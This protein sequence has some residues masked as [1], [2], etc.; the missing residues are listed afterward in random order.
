MYVC[1]SPSSANAS[2]SS[3]RTSRV[4]WSWTLRASS[5][6]DTLA[7]PLA[8]TRSAAPKYGMRSARCAGGTGGRSPI[9][10]RSVV[11]SARRLGPLELA[12]VAQADEEQPRSVLRNAVLEGVEHARVDAVAELA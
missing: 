7:H 1:P 9:A 12:G 6:R 8:G 10:S 11:I 5:G 2:A 4:M 3:G